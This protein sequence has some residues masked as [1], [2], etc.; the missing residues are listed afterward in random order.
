MNFNLKLKRYRAGEGPRYIARPRVVLQVAAAPRTHLPVSLFFFFFFFPFPVV[1]VIVFFLLFFY[2]TKLV[3]SFT[4]LLHFRVPCRASKRGFPLSLPQLAIELMTDGG[5]RESAA[6]IP[7]RDRINGDLSRRYRVSATASI[8][9][10]AAGDLHRP[11]GTDDDWR[12]R[13]RRFFRRSRRTSASI[14]GC[15]LH[16]HATLLAP[17]AINFKPTSRYLHLLFARLI[18]GIR[19]LRAVVRLTS[20]KLRLNPRC[21]LS[22]VSPP[23]PVSWW[24]TG[25][26]RGGSRC[27]RKR[28]PCRSSARRKTARRRFS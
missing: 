22:L 17:R 11:V 19:K 7:R 8:S 13:R 18:A 1:I 26:F 9:L 5:H 28:A 20:V 6:L 4:R 15:A 23:P 3:L 24:R 10:K 25:Y 27:P 16:Y 12:Y 14:E 21:Y 2:F